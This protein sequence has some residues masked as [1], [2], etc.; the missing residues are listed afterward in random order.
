[1]PTGTT[2]GDWRADV[3]TTRF[4]G[5]RRVIEHWENSLLTEACGGPA[6]PDGIVHPIHLFHVPIE[7]AGVSIAE[8]F[9][10][11]RAEGPD[12]VGLV[13]YEWAWQHPLREGVEYQCEGGIVGFD[14][15][16]DH[17]SSHDE[18]VFAIDVSAAGQ[19][20]ARVTNTWHIWRGAGA[21]PAK[22]PTALRPTG[23]GASIDRWVMPDVRAE[24]MRTTA[25]VLR[26]PNPVHWDVDAARGRGRDGHVVNQGPL[27]V[28]YLA[29]M[30]M[31]WQGPECLRRLTVHFPGRVFDGD[32]VTANGVV[33]ATDGDLATCEVW[34]ER[35]DGSQPVIGTAVVEMAR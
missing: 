8:L 3:R 16:V 13:S 12:R 23:P 17:S 28:G 11:V 4:G 31:A 27:N 21:R 26:D 7:G 15:V 30:L 33:V 29:N 14:A 24:R 22:G 34:L 10:L 25:A 5:G 1:M 18:L 19:P 6:L 35:P 20:V 9:S 2:N 32:H